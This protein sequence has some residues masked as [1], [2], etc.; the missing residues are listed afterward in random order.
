MHAIVLAH[1]KSFRI[2]PADVR[3]STRTI[4]RED[5]EEVL[6][7][8]VMQV[9]VALA[10][11]RGAVV[12]RDDLV[13][14]CWN[15]RV[16]GDDAINRVIGRLRR[17]AEG[18]GADVFAIDTITRVGYRLRLLSDEA[19]FEPT[20]PTTEQPRGRAH[21]SRREL[22]IGGAVGAAAVTGGGAWWLWNERQAGPDVSEATA[23]LIE[24]ARFALWQNTP[25]GQNQA[26]GIYRQLVAENPTYADAWGRLAMAYS[27]TAHWR[28]A[29][30]GEVL[31]TRAR[32]AAQQALSLDRQD[33]H[34]LYGLALA[35]PWIGNWLSIERELRD[36]LEFSPKESEVNL[37]LALTLWAAGR[38]R[39]ALDHMKLIFSL[40]P[41]PGIYM[42]RA[43]LLWSAGRQE[44]LDSILDEATKLYP[45]H[46]GVW[47]TRFYAEMMGGRPEAALALAADTTNRPTNIDPEEIDSVVRVAKAI[48]SR[49]QP[50]TIAVTREWMERAR[51]G[52]GYAENAAQFMATLGRFDEAFA[53][54]RAYYFSEGFDCGEVRFERAT[55]SF[56]PRN[57]RQTYFLFNPGFASL[58]ADARFNELAERLHLTD[59]WRASGHLPDYLAQ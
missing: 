14:A 13:E 8:R 40:A 12:S 11:G 56:T 42:F 43:T 1:E 24:Q 55:G 31:R 33:V 37:G 20:R 44:E 21:L 52:A 35:R 19:V 26:I 2:G 51:R 49:S 58:R 25:E 46:F 57:D 6:E 28:E 18:I 59:Y 27:W 48:Q 7:P 22:V 45:T 15:G 34:A 32:S 10:K 17:T 54:L 29:S 16:V 53:V 38:I 41:T 39:E 23:S 36:A 30:V 9:L 4:A 47:F 5:K 3:P 50:D